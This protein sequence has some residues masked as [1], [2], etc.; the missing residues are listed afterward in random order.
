MACPSVCA[1]KDEIFDVYFTNNPVVNYGATS[2]A[3]GQ[4]MEL[5]NGGLL[6][7]GI[8]ESGQKFYPSTLHADEDIDKT[9]KAFQD[10]FP[11]LIG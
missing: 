1:A 7:R 5:F 4:M 3:H 9:I 6:Q 8:L 11:T 2:I 10:V